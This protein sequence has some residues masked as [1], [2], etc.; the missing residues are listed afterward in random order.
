MSS[1][2]EHFQQHI[3]FSMLTPTVRF[4]LRF[5]TRMKALRELAEDAYYRE[6]RRRKLKM[7]VIEEVMSISMTKA[8]VLSNRLKKRFAEQR[9]ES[10][11][12]ERRIMVLLW[13]E[14]LTET[15]IA[16][17]FPDLEREDL[18]A[19]LEDMIDSRQLEVIKGRTVRYG[20]ADTRYRLVRDTWVSRLEAL[21]SFMTSVFQV[22]QARFL[23][24]D[25]RALVRTL[26]FHIRPEDRA[27][28]E[29]FY[30]KQLFP[31]IVELDQAAI[32]AKKEQSREDTTSVSYPV[33]LSVLWAPDD[34]AIEDE[35][36]SE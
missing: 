24:N 20:L 6:G 30:Q 31:L 8:S 33:R 5:K 1:D 34:E 9:Y 13:A 22:V 2:Q 18:T 27:R 26:R 15:Q 28:L 4:A 11:N 25:E 12:I 21:N 23:E 36:Q 3:L 35:E 32:E 10:E 14:P 16:K 7:R 19:M 29:E 17:A